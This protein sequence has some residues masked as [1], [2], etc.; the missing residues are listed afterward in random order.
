MKFLNG[1]WLSKEGYSL[2]YPSKAYR[3]DNKEDCLRIFAPC[4]EIKH[5]G[6]T[7]GGP[8]L[9]IE[10]SAPMKDVIHVH[11]YHYKGC[12]STGP[13]FVLNTSDIPVEIREEDEAVWFI[14]GGLNARIDKINY[15]IDYYRNGERLTGSGWRHLAYIEHDDGTTFMREQL[16]LEVG[17]CVYG[18][19]ERFTPFVKNGQTVNIWNEDGGTCTEQSYKNIPFYLTNRGYGVFVN[20]PGCVSFEICSEVV[21]RVQF[22]V[23]GES[24]DYFIIGG[25]DCKAAISNY[26][27]LTGRPALPPAWSFGLWLSTSFTTNYD[28]KTV[29]NFINGMNERHI[30]L[31]VFHFDCFWMK[32]FNWCDFTWDHGIFAD[33]EQMLKNLKSKGL[34]IC[35]WI[36]S[37]VS[38]ESILFDEGMEK[39]YFILNTDGSVWQWDMWQPGM[40]IVDFTNP[41]ACEWFGSKLRTLAD[42][43]VDCFKTDFGERIPTENVV[44]YDGSDPK[45]MHNF[46]TYLYNK[47]VFETLKAAGKEAVVF[48]RSATA[49]S[50]Q[51]PVHW[52]GD[53][54]ANFSSMAESLRGGLSL[55]LCGFGFWSHDIGGFENTATADVYKRWL[56]FGMLSSHS[57]LHGSTTYR[58]PWLF[59]EEAVDVLRFFANLKCRLMPYLFN[60]AVQATRMGIPCA[61]AMFLEFPD[62]P[63][64]LPLDRQYMLGDSLLVAP[65]FSAS[66]VAEYYLPG[67]EW[68][69][70]LTG[71]IVTGGSFR[72]EKHGYMSLPL[73][74]RPDSLLAL[75]ASDK[76]TVYDYADRVSLLLTPLSNGATAKTTVFEQGGRSALTVTVTRTGCTLTVT[77]EGDGKPWS[78]KL[79]GIR[80]AD[81]EG[82]AFEDGKIGIVFKPTAFTG[83]YIVNIQ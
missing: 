5:R 38:Q 52:G 31:S 63:A 3:I 28:E 12:K 56:A 77:A 45:K 60:T 10:L 80:S 15:N 17:E 68:Y 36:N 79:C 9:T 48:A 76:E 34:H 44:Y 39:G 78:L 59:D 19:G 26:T 8:A 24:L 58:V 74:V 55:G 62:D 42:M 71:Q 51:F 29:T 81:G 33:P 16:D 25:N 22:S 30:P 2:H 4:N 47:T 54:T 21:S 57:R 73:F 64:C 61:R 67:G 53:C 49:G 72:R 23:Q 50:Q 70:L 37:Y 43:G 14:S 65:I 6:D 13:S 75:G 41:A 35:V 27:A 46:Y 83:N 1:Y 66:G 11:I 32:E 82:G 7:L 40:A 69:S 20:D 18:T